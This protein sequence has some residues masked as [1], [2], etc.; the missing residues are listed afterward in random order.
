ML[1]CTPVTP[2]PAGRAGG[3]FGYWPPGMLVPEPPRS[4]ST[5]TTRGVA[6]LMVEPRTSIFHAPVGSTRAEP[7]TGPLSG[8]LCTRMLFDTRIDELPS[9][10]QRCL[11]ASYLA[12]MSVSSSI[13]GVSVT[14]AVS[15]VGAAQGRRP[16]AV[17]A[18]LRTR[19][20]IVIAV[21]VL[22]NR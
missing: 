21:S 17:S 20:R 19:S 6:G 2:G 22:G 4:D 5:E 3:G 1:P 7:M 11:L 14:C 15:Q 18:A 10:V 9:T 12:R 16:G 13:A 8:P